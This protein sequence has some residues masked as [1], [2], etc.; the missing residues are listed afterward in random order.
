MVGLLMVTLVDLLNQGGVSADE[1][2]SEAIL[3][4]TMATTPAGQNMHNMITGG[5]VKVT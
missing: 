2:E 5:E 1:D 3:T 4:T